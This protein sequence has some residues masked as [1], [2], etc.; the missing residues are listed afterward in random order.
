ME[1]MF[2]TSI[3]SF[4]CMFS[5]LLREKSS[6]KPL[7]N[8]KMWAITKLNAFEDDKF[9]VAKM[10]IFLYDR[11]ENIVGNGENAGY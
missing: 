7:P 11:V 10:L 1:K 6:F 5:T 8:N 9:N 2:V 4:S 3:F